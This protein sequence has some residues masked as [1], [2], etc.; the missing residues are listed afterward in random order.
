MIFDNSGAFINS[1]T[2]KEPLKKLREFSKI[3]IE[4]NNKNQLTTYSKGSEYSKYSDVSDYLYH[5]D[6]LYILL[7]N[8]EIVGEKLHR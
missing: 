6:R 7:N 1:I 3:R 4:L 5:R 2:E 8:G